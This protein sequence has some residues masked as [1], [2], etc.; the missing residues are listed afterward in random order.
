[1]NQNFKY[2]ANCTIVETAANGLDMAGVYYWDN[3]MDGTVT[4]KYEGKYL[5]SIVHVYGLAV[6]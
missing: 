6:A 4:Y 5:T 1:M 2:I 3:E